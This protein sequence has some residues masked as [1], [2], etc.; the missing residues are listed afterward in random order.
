M[1]RDAT[2]YR[3]FA[4]EAT[5]QA[6]MERWARLLELLAPG[7]GIRQ[8]RQLRSLIRMHQPEFTSEFRR[9]IRAARRAH[10]RHP[11]G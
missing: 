1:N 5:S 10:L 9:I 3:Y 6:D 8:C 2:L 7:L 4:H 11:S